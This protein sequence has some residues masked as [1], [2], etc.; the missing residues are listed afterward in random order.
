MTQ[1]VLKGSAV[2]GR[3]IGDQESMVKQLLL[4][5][6][7]GTGAG[8]LR[9]ALAFIAAV[10]V[11][12]L[13]VAILVGFGVTAIDGGKHMGAGL[14]LTLLIFTAFAVAVSFVGAMA[15]KQGLMGIL[16]RMLETQAPALAGLGARLLEKFLR[17]I[18]YQ[19]GGPVTGTL[20]NQWRKFLKLQETLPRPLPFLLG[21]LAA[22]VPLSDSITSVATTGM[23]L[24]EVA[25]QVMDCMVERATQGGFRPEAGPLLGALTVQFALWVV[26]AALLH[27]R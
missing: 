20:L 3:P 4:A 24:Q 10:A 26:L 16:S 23:T 6:A 17:Q 9:S 15:Y 12:G 27:Y 8:V 22:K 21:S 18:D 5:A 13:G 25:E 7:R 1:H 2:Q 19:P 14:V 11:N